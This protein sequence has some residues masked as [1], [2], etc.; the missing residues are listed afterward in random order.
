[1]R[2][3]DGL[4]KL[5]D[6]VVQPRDFALSHVQVMFDLLRRLGG[7]LRR[8]AQFPDF[9]A[10]QL[11]MNVQGVEGIAD[12]VGHAG[13]QQGQGMNAL[14]LDGFKGLLARLGR[15]VQDQCHPGTAPRFDI[16]RRGVKAQKARA[17]ISDLKL[18][19]D[20]ARPAFDRARQDA[21]PIQFRQEV[22][23]G[24]AFHLVRRPIE[25]MRDG[26]V[27]ID[28]PALFIE[29]Q[30]TVLDGIEQRFQEIALARQPLHDGLQP[31]GIQPPDAAQHLVQKT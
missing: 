31:F 15:V 4:E 6:D 27:E 26:V 29:H 10:H 11:E 20:D 8:R 12:F 16:Q 19:P 17:R 25:Q 3:P 30:H 1:M 14:A 21:V 9:A 2:R 24:P 7:V 13:G 22:G 18:V 23:D 5:G 28:D